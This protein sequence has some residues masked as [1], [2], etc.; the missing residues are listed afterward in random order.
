MLAGLESPAREM[1]L[2]EWSRLRQTIKTRL[3]KR[4]EAQ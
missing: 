3:A 1:T 4:P 2:E